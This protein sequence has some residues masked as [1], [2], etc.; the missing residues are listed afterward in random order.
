M[1]WEDEGNEPVRESNAMK[2]LREKAEADSKLIRE[3]SEQLNAM[4]RE[5]EATKLTSV[6]T[7]KGLDP[8]V[9]EIVKAAGVEP[10]EQAVEAWLKDFGDV[11]VKAPGQEPT[12]DAGAEQPPASAVPDGEQEALAA[13]AAA[14]QGAVP[15]KGLEGIEAQINAATDIESLL[16]VLGAQG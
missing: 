6:V 9:A 13:M 10:T 2:V 3:M 8:K 7:S 5:S 12:G 14:A 1:F 11:F 4:K 15:A 16:K